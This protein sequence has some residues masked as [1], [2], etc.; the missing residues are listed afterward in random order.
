MLRLYFMLRY[1]YNFIIMYPLIILLRYTTKTV[2]INYFL[3]GGILCAC[4]LLITALF[5]RY[6]CIKKHLEAIEDIPG[7]KPS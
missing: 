7:F 5:V 6:L 3:A 2:T 4:E 1:A